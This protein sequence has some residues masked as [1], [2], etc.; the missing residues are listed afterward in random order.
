MVRELQSALEQIKK[1]KSG[2][3]LRP[4]QYGNE[5]H[6]SITY[7]NKKKDFQVIINKKD[8]GFIGF[9]KTWEW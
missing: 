2:L 5:T 7:Q 3:Q 8:G 6:I 1:G 4:I 9:G